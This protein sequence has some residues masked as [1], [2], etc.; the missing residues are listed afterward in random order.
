MPK[1]NPLN[2]YSLALPSFATITS[3]N[4]SAHPSTSASL[5]SP[6]N[7][8]TENGNI[9]PPP[10]AALYIPAGTATAHK[11]NTLPTCV[12]VPKNVLSAMGSFATSAIVGCVGAVGTRRKSICERICC[13]ARRRLGRVS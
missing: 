10:L 5:L 3:S 4:S 6:A 8:V 11:S 12:K 1:S 9:T 13:A 2:I 7:S